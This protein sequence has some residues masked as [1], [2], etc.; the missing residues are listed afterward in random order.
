MYIIH[1]N[2]IVKIKI[3]ILYK[4]DKRHFPF[5]RTSFIGHAGT[6]KM[7]GAHC[8]C[9]HA[10]CYKFSSVRGFRIFAYKSSC[11][12]TFLSTRNVYGGKVFTEAF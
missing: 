4:C 2:F 12:F 3:N 7:D 5:Y 1:I 8:N 10:H 9:A 6:S 11:I